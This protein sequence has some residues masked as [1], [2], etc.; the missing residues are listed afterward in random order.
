MDTKINENLTELAIQI[1][2]YLTDIIEEKTW[3][4]GEL[5]RLNM[6]LN[7]YFWNNEYLTN[8]L[9]SFNKQFCEILLE[10]DREHIILSKF[11]DYLEDID[12][13]LENSTNAIV[14]LITKV[15]NRISEHIQAR[16]LDITE[17]TGHYDNIIT[18]NVFTESNC[19]VKD[20]KVKTTEENMADILMHLP[21]IKRSEID[22][23]EDLIY[24]SYENI[25]YLKEEKT[26]IIGMI[27]KMSLLFESCFT[28]S[29]YL[30]DAI[31]YFQ[32]YLTSYLESIDFE[33]TVFQ[34]IIAFAKRFKNASD[35][36][37]ASDELG[38]EHI[39]NELQIRFDRRTKEYYNILNKYELIAATNSL[40]K[41]NYK[42][43]SPHLN[44]PEENKAL[45]KLIP[46]E[47]L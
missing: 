37:N 25:D 5:I 13:D 32:E 4:I 22:A 44:T 30:E 43:L 29:P 6:Q 19:E 34:K 2:T 20:Y 46:E 42:T 16:T 39:V 47:R 11:D 45:L 1:Q 31:N 18:L 17:Y 40:K 38:M 3:L 23:R 36:V 12:Y 33:I 24:T 14:N 9:E 26:W 41:D 21:Q 15:G 10:V 28:N 27:M 8:A 35:F 7:M